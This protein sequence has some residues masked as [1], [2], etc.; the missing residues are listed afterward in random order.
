L[1]STRFT[2]SGHRKAHL[3]EIAELADGADAG[4]EILEFGNGER[5]VVFSHAGGA[6]ADVDEAVLVAVDERLEQHSAHQ[7]EDRCVRPDAERQREDHN[8]R[9]PF[10]AHQRVERNF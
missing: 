6:L 7:R 10:A 9:Q 5:C 4:F 8:G 3:G 2:E 1:H